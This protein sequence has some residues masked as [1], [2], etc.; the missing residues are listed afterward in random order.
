[1]KASE[2]REYTYNVLAY[3]IVEQLQLQIR[4]L[5]LLLLVHAHIKSGQFVAG[6]QFSSFLSKSRFT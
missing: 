3:C 6:S 5:L 2:I 1:M 4:D